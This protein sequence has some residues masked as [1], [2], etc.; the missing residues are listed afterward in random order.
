MPSDAKQQRRRFWRFALLVLVLMLPV[1]AAALYA[2]PSADDFGY[3]QN[4]R[5]A[6]LQGG[7][8]WQLLTAAVRTDVQFFN[9][10]QGLY[11]SGFLLA[12]QP[13]IF[14]GKWYALTT[15]FIIAVLFLCLWGCL[16]LVGRRLAAGHRYLPAGLALLFTY[17]FVQGMPNQVEGLFWFNGAANYI[18]FFALSV[19]N[20]GLL[21]HLLA[22]GSCP[23]WAAA[24]S[25]AVSVVVSGGHHVAALLDM[26]VLLLA[27]LI[28]L[29]RKRPVVLLPFAAGLAGLVINLTAPGT[30]VRMDGFSSASMPEAVIKSFLLTIFNLIRWLDV[31]LLCLLALLTP[32][33][34]ML[35]RSLPAPDRMSLLAGPAVTFVM[36][37]EMVW[38]PSYTMG[39]IGAGRLINVVWMTFVLGA[40]GSWCALVVWAAHRIDLTRLLPRKYGAL[41]AA[42]LLV[43]MACIGSHTVK[44]GLDNH[45]ATS[46]E[47]AYELLEGVPQ[48]FAAAHDERERLL[49]EPGVQDV[50]IRPLTMEE[51]PYLLYFSDVTPGPD[52]W[53]LAGYY[54]K[55]SV[56]VSEYPS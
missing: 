31:P 23:V 54:G 13:G 42:A 34:V 27:L 21:F 32:L 25:A 38:L 2:R 49:L 33:A 45:F 10:W 29:R 37:W 52:V 16:S 24:V 39:G 44:E 19:L 12:F 14:G 30:R 6:V 9:T 26:L 40:S 28:G 50:T 20:A 5:A 47:A 7:S 51:K 43:C 1:L 41:A 46:L 35:A 36:M 53:G 48:R 3:A 8:L 15:Y 22:S 4:T 11:S 17:T 18:P 56:T 55:Q